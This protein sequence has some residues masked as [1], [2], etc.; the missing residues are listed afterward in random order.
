METIRKQIEKADRG[1]DYITA[2]VK[3]LNFS[4]VKLPF[5]KR[6]HIKVIFTKKAD[7]T[8]TPKMR[9]KLAIRREVCPA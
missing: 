8:A 4:S 3:I 6:E 7:F 5:I 9:K 2:M 1:Q